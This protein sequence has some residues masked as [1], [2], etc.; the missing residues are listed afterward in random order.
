[1]AEADWKKL[2]LKCGLEI[3][4]QLNTHKLF[5]E[6]PST[7]RYDLPH[8]TILRKQ[9]A[10]AGETGEKDIAARSE[11]LRERTFVYEGYNDTTCLV[12]L[13]EEPPHPMNR[14]AL[15]IAL[16]AALMFKMKVVDEV[17]VMRKTVVNGSNTSGFQR[18]ALI[19]QDGFINT[20]AG[21]VRISAIALEEDAARETGR[22][23]DEV[24]F[25]LDRLGIPLLEIG[26]EADIHTPEQAKEAAEKI[27]LL[28]RMTG[29]MKRGLGTIRQDVNVSIAGGNRVEIKGFQELGDIPKIIALEAERQ[30]KILELRNKFK[31]R[32]AAAERNFKDVSR[33]LAD[34]PSNL[35]KAA[36]E[37]KDEIIGIKLRGFNEMLKKQIQGER[38]VAKEIVDYLKHFT[39]MQGFIHTDELP[40]YGIEEKHVFQLKQL[41]GAGNEDAVAFVFGKKAACERALTLIADRAE[42]LAAGVPEEVRAA[43]PD[44]TT[45]FLRPMPGAARMYPET[46]AMPVEITK[47]MLKKIKLPD[48][49]EEKHAKYRKL[50]LSADLATQLVH[51]E[52]M[53]VFEELVKKFH[54]LSPTLIAN[55]LLSARDEIKRRYEAN[56]ENLTIAH[57]ED[58]LSLLMQD[59]VAK[60]AVIEILAYLARSPDKSA[61]EAAKELKLTKISKKELERIIDK[62]FEESPKLVE[63]KQFGVLMGFVMRKV[64]GRIDGEIVSDTLKKKLGAE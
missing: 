15:E 44:L 8:F 20:N 52:E 3:H 57:F 42:Q 18:T 40:K 59:R 16:Q 63:D 10:V 7:M 48:S 41:F 55:M 23:E 25:R 11:E 61:E 51:S 34:A 35:I 37:R 62:I 4:Q 9:R 47:E 28:L 33:I 43:N 1:M 17:Q 31:Q 46:D 2:G 13:D 64:R 50:G 30:Q 60:E 38:T 29:H 12:E 45:R 27:G 24:K 54:K 56:A 19:G 5:C 21:K 53:T 39:G 32:Q 58:A 14:E 6:C 49:P 36:F 26:T 22:S